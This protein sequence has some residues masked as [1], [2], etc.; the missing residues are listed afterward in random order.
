MKKNGMHGLCSTYGG[1]EK[2]IQSSVRES[3]GKEATWT[4]G[5]MQQV[6]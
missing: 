1:E 4:F 6:P 3:W 5:D 2:Y